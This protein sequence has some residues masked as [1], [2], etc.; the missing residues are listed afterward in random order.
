MSD[1][2]D[3]AISG[4]EEEKGAGPSHSGVAKHPL[5]H[6]WA[7]WTRKMS[8]EE[9]NQLELV[10]YSGPIHVVRSPGQVR[11]AV[12]ELR[13]DSML[14]FDTETRPSFR[15]G[16]VYKPALLQLAGQDATF[17][18]RVKDTGLPPEL[19]GLLA[20]AAILKVGVA[21]GRDV[22]DLR[23]IEPFAPAG[24]TDLGECARRAGIQHHGLRG[25]A[26]VVLGCRVS[27]GARTTNWDR[28]DLPMTSLRYAATDAWIARGI[29]QAMKDQGCP[30][31]AIPSTHWRDPRASSVESLPT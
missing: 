5:A 25:L 27:K 16:V 24:F 4:H 10:S 31:P 20:D 23:Q 17:L 3:Q 21:V 9:I 22:Q 12:R 14:G 2:N 19:T 18:F 26:A 11:D 30:L 8:G 29:Y 6:L 13:R 7:H 28:P 15:K 1:I